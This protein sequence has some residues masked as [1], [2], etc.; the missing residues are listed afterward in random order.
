MRP[1]FIIPFPFL[2]IDF[3]I[4]P[5]DESSILDVQLIYPKGVYCSDKSSIKYVS[6]LFLTWALLS[7]LSCINSKKNHTEADLQILMLLDLEDNID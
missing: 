1:H 4:R 3:R 7:H 6:R 2:L 5:K